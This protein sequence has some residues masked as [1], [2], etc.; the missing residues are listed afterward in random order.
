MGFIGYG[1]GKGRERPA[2]LQEE[3]QADLQALERTGPIVLFHV[4]NDLPH[5][6][7]NFFQG[8]ISR[9]FNN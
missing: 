4:G 8:N 5:S 7:S 3:L 9:T 1:M 2:I 6:Q